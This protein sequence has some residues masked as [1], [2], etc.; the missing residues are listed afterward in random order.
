MDLRKQERK[1]PKIRRERKEKEKKKKKKKKNITR[2]DDGQ[3]L[4]VDVRES[5]P[6]LKEE[7]ETEVFG[8][9]T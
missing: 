5:T 7:E 4:G 1:R 6:M 2:S 9:M 8:L 3:N